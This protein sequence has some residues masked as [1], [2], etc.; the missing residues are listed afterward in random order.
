MQ[1]F[2]ISFLIEEEYHINH[3][4][5]IQFNRNHLVVHL[6]GKLSCQEK[7]DWKSKLVEKQVSDGGAWT[8]YITTTRKLYKICLKYWHFKIHLIFYSSVKSQP[9]L[10]IVVFNKSSLIKRWY[11]EGK[12][13]Y[14][15]HDW[16]AYINQFL[17][18]RHDY[19]Q[20]TRTWFLTW[21]YLNWKDL[22]RIYKCG[23][24]LWMKD[25]KKVCIIKL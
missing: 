16:W 13:L 2:G 23:R 20:R 21:T 4:F 15:K 10:I 25:F 22:I 7:N 1:C 9:R 3:Y 6:T 18:D 8:W 17:C 5:Y 24:V 12:N 11:I 19:C 14:L